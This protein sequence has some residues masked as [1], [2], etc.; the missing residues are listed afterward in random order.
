MLLSSE[1]LVASTPV[2]ARPGPSGSMRGVEVRATVS[3]L[4]VTALCLTILGG[5]SGSSEIAVYGDGEIS[6]PD[7]VAS[8]E[9]MPVGAVVYTP[10]DEGLQVEIVLTDAEPSWVY[11]V[12]V[13]DPEF[14][15][16]K[17]LLHRAEDLIATDESGSGAITI[18]VEDLAPGPLEVQ[19]NIV[20][21]LQPGP[22][23]ERLREMAPSTFTEVDLP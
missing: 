22:A 1:G 17:V 4:L 18:L 5:C 15:D 12:E 19:V 23:N 14:C 11:Y 13:L 8:D 16:T 9:S 20:S 3:S 10:T 6:C 2:P 21:G 7:H